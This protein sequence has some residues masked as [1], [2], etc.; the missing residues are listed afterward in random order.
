M[1]ARTSWG[2]NPWRACREFVWVDDCTARPAPYWSNNLSWTHTDPRTVS[3]MCLSRGTNREP[4]SVESLVQ[5]LFWFNDWLCYHT[6][7]QPVP[8]S[9]IFETNISVRSIALPTNDKYKTLLLL[10]R[11]YGAVMM[12][13]LL[14]L[15]SYSM[16]CIIESVRSGGVRLDSHFPNVLDGCYSYSPRHS[17]TVVQ[18]SCRTAHKKCVAMPRISCERRTFPLWTAIIPANVNL[19]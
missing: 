11:I 16:S 14:Y 18:Y 7:Q 4:L 2:L 3:R 19:K 9:R 1:A 12:M 8:V 13:I 5:Y 6:G 17:C 10:A 15:M